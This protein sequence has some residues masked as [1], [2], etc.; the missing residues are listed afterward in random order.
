VAGVIHRFAAGVFT[1][2]R[3]HVVIGRRLH[4]G[5]C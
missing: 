5:E 4:R 1:E 2:R 3:V